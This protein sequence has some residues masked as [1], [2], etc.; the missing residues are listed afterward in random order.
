M[1]SVADESRVGDFREIVRVDEKEL[2]GHVTETVARNNRNSDRETLVTVPC[3]GK[4]AI[5]SDWSKKELRQPPTWV[6]KN[7]WAMTA[8]YDTW[9]V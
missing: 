8:D 3:V 5:T 4:K 9:V 7:R 6:V 2:H 1:T